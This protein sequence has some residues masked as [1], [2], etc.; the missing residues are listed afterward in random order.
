M[1]KKRSKALPPGTKS[2]EEIAAE[3][4]LGPDGPREKKPRKLYTVQ[5]AGEGQVKIRGQEQK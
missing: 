2:A 4:G 3:I 5:N 1:G